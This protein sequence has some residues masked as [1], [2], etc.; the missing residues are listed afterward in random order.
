MTLLLKIKKNAQQKTTPTNTP[1]TRG[2]AATAPGFNLGRGR[3]AAAMRGVVSA[4]LLLALVAAFAPDV[5]SG[6]LDQMHSDF[7]LVF[8]SCNRHDREQKLWGPIRGRA[9]HSLPYFSL[10]SA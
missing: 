2:T 1:N 5:V 3:F 10:T 9:L 4:L 7:R 6:E 8:A